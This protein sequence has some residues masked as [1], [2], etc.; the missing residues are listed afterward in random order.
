MN[1]LSLMAVKELHIRTNRRLQQD[2]KVGLIKEMNTVRGELRAIF[3]KKATLQQQSLALVSK[4]ATDEASCV[5]VEAILDRIKRDIIYQGILSGG[6]IDA[7]TRTCWKSRW[8]RSTNQ[9]LEMKRF[10]GFVVERVSRLHA[11]SREVEDV[12]AEVQG[13]MLR[14]EAC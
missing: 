4:L 5:D 14:A 13:F 9:G 3:A 12:M 7:L 2:W 8:V 6:I 11:L 10:V 1:I